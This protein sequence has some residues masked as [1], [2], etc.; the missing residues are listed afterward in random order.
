MCIGCAS[1][2]SLNARNGLT[3]CSKMDRESRKLSLQPSKMWTT[4][5]RLRLMYLPTSTCMMLTMHSLQSFHCCHACTTHIELGGCTML[6]SSQGKHS[7]VSP[8]HVSGFE[9]WTAVLLVPCSLSTLRLTTLTF[10]DATTAFDYSGYRILQ[11]VIVKQC[12]TCRRQ[13]QAVQ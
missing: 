7:C 11:A 8:V 2:R 6:Q 12:S 10:G 13:H 3:S 4:L 9:L 1:V 5:I